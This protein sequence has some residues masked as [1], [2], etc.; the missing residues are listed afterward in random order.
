MLCK[1]IEEKYREYKFVILS[2][3]FFSLLLYSFFMT[4]QLTNNCD[5]FWQQN[6]YL[7]GGW[8]ISCGRWLWPYLDKL[9]FGIHID[10]LTTIGSLAFFI[11]GYI[12][13][14]D[15]FKVKSKGIGVLGGLI[16][17]SSPVILVFLSY[18]YMALTFATSFLFSVFASYFL[19]KV[20]SRVFSIGLSMLFICL[21]MSFYQAH[22]A[23]VGVLGLSFI[24]Y[25]C[26]HNISLNK[27]LEFFIKLAISVVGG[28]LLYYLLLNIYLKFT[29]QEL[30]GY[31]GA[32]SVSIIGILKNL[33]VGIGKAYKSFFDFFLFKGEF[34]YNV[35]DEKE[36]IGVFATV[37]GVM[38]L[39]MI[40]YIFRQNMYNAII[41][42]LALVFM[43]IAATATLLLAEDAAL[44]PQ[45]S[46]SLII[47]MVVILLLSGLV[48]EKSEMMVHKVLPEKIVVVL[49]TVF[50]TFLIYGNSIQN[51][52]DQNAMEEG[53]N[54]TVTMFTQVIDDLKEAGALSEGHELFFIGKPYDNKTFKASPLF[55]QAN[56]YAKVGSFTSSGDGMYLFYNALLNKLMQINVPVAYENYENKA[57]DEYYQSMPCY[58]ED[59]YFVVWDTVIVKISEP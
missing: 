48:W 53:K 50:S 31:I 6:Y 12:L 25:L 2:M 52:L 5:G 30:G 17:I 40:A 29:G 26:I 24:I 38:I 3:I 10:P 20:N 57:Y 34:K 41:V 32:S 37:F 58:P 8:E 23:V 18:R 19:V 55:D 9:L 35:F 45:M 22:L 44:F 15:M 13:V 51:L 4:Q 46:C 43:P 36:F 49:V 39:F 59:G 42:L 16:F 11:V 28:G 56:S 21:S 27:I 1:K 47:A 54:A 33:P 7:A 14:L